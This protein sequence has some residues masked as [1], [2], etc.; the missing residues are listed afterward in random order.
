MTRARSGTKLR[1]GAIWAQGSGFVKFGT[2]S[3]STFQNLS[4]LDR[5]VNSATSTLRELQ[6]QVAVLR[7]RLS[8]LDST[9]N[10]PS[11]GADS[12]VDKLFLSRVSGPFRE[13][14]V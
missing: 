2:D 13:S 1:N 10:Y 11:D 5:E 7:A 14:G 6:R 12:G 8:V 3:M 9:K 4:E